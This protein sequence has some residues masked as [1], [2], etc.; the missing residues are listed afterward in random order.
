LEGV[1]QQIISIEAKQ[2]DDIH[3]LQNQLDQMPKMEAKKEAHLSSNERWE[4]FQST[5]I[6]S[7]DLDAHPFSKDED[8]F[9]D[10]SD[11]EVVDT[12][13]RESV[14][15]Q[16]PNLETPRPRITIKLDDIHGKQERNTD[17]LK[18][19][20]RGAVN[21]PSSTDNEVLKRARR[22]LKRTPDMRPVDLAEKLKISRQYA[23][24]LK[25]KIVAEQPA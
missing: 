10:I 1:S 6:S 4:M 11:D 21:K 18:P 15:N 3:R 12:G 24:T 23:S 20:N 7:D 17:K 2:G 14:S 9:A 25:A 8:I 16:M 13:E 19:V 5:D 22:I